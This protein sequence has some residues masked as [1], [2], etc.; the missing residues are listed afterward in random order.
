MSTKLLLLASAFI[1]SA[2]A[3]VGMQYSPP[4]AQ[5]DSAE[6]LSGGEGVFIVNIDDN[7][8]YAGRTKVED[9]IRLHANRSVIVSHEG[10]IDLRQ[11]YFCRSQFSF[12]PEKGRLYRMKSEVRERDTGRKTIFGNPFSVRYCAARV[13]RVNADGMSEEVNVTPL[14]MR[15]RALTCIRAE[16]IGVK[17]APPN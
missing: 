17:P 4:T 2:C 11:E 8:C 13:E 6:L 12:V 1:L 10:F 3:S 9:T 15:Q 7:G 16:P 14:A 5:D